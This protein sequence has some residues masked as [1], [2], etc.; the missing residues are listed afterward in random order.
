MPQFHGI[1]PFF[2]ATLGYVGVQSTSFFTPSIWQM[3]D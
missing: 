2:S 3:Y 1:A